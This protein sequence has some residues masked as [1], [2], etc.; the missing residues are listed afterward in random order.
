[1]LTKRCGKRAPSQIILGL[2]LSRISWT[3]TPYSTHFSSG[4][5]VNSLTARTINWDEVRVRH[6]VVSG[7]DDEYSIFYLASKRRKEKRS[8]CCLFFI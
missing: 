5:A 7:E 8:H 3:M 4:D 1:M 6:S 2:Q